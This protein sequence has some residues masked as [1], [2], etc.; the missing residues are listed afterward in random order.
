MEVPASG[1][2]SQRVWCSARC[3]Q[4]T[5]RDRKLLR[6]EEVLEAATPLS[7]TL[8][9]ELFKDQIGRA[10][11]RKAIRDMRVAQ[12]ETPSEEEEKEVQSA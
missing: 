11:E 5:L 2:G 12:R 8:A 3:H 1:R 9:L 4:Q 10:R 6:L 7:C